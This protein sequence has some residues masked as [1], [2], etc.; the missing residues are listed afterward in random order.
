MELT[1]SFFKLFFFFFNNISK[2]TILRANHSSL[3]VYSN[4]AIV[5]SQ[6]NCKSNTS[7]LFGSSHDK[8]CNYICENYFTL[9][10]HYNHKL[11]S[12]AM[13]EMAYMH[14]WTS[15]NP[16]CPEDSS[17]HLVFHFSLYSVVDFMWKT[18]SHSQDFIYTVVSVL[19]GIFFFKQC[20]N[21]LRSFSY[22]YDKNTR[23]PIS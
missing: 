6:I 7:I 23:K 18:V 8:Y 15:H 11:G 9:Y 20:N 3:Y 14:F 5:N 13:F 12:K 19:T 17:F 10:L 2:N 16:D 22:L 1:K 4:I 21:R